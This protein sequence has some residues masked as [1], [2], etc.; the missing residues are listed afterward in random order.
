[1]NIIE[2]ARQ[3]IKSI[4]ESKKPSGKQ[5][6]SEKV[7]FIKGM[8]AGVKAIGRAITNKPGAGV[9]RGGELA[10]GLS[11]LGKTAWQHKLKTGAAIGVPI[12][13]AAKAAQIDAENKAKKDI[14]TVSESK[15][16]NEIFQ[17]VGGA[18]GSA[19]RGVAGVA[20]RVIAAPYQIGAGF[21]KG[22]LGVKDKDQ[23]YL[24]A[25]KKQS[26]INL[27]K[28]KVI[29]DAKAQKKKI[30]AKYGK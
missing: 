20:G 24:D 6:L 12:A 13:I 3:K 17:Q 7:G 26:K 28:K 10:R 27:Q 11:K 9:T 19:A 25:A 29:A 21:T 4:N 1:M 5:S 30:I 2:K 15:E 14:G 18:V 23:A 16:V 22:L 8:G